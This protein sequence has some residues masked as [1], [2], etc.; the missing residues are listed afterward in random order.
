MQSVSLCTARGIRGPYSFLSSLVSASPQPGI[1]QLFADDGGRVLVCGDPGAKILELL[2]EQLDI[3][4]TIAEGLAN[5]LYRLVADSSADNASLPYARRRRISVT[6]VERHIFERLE[7][8]DPSSLNVALDGGGLKPVDFVTP[9]DEPGFYQ[10]VKVVPGHIASGLIEDRPAD[11]NLVVDALKR[12]GRVL[13]SGPSGSGKSAL[14]WLSSYALNGTCRWFEIT[15]IA[16]ATQVADIERFVR[17]RRPTKDSPIGLLFDDIGSSNSVLWNT[18][19]V[20]MRRMNAVLLL[21]SVRQ[22]DAELITEQAEFE[23]IRVALCE[24][25]AESIWRNLASKKLTSWPHWREPFEKSGG[26]MLEYVHILTQG[27]RLGKVIGDQVRIREREGRWDEL[28]IIRT[29]AVLCARGGDVQTSRLLELLDLEP[30]RASRSLRRLIDEH[31][32]RESE[33]GVLGGLH[34]LRSEALVRASH[35]D[36]VWFSANTLCESLPAATMATLPSVLQSTL[37][38][39]GAEM[40][41]KVLCALAETLGVTD[42][43]E[44][45][46]GILTGLGLATLE[47]CIGSLISILTRREIPR[48]QWPVAAMFADPSVGVPGL[49]GLDQLNSTVTEFRQATNKDLRRVCLELLPEGHSVPKRLDME[50]AN[51]LLS[52]IVPICGGESVPMPF[53]FLDLL[54]CRERDIGRIAK[55]M[56]TAYLI[57]SDLANDIAVYLG[58]T[59]AL[60]EL[61]RAQIP[62]VT[63]PEIE[64]SGAHGRTIRSNWFHLADQYQADPHGAVCGICETLIALVP[65]ADAAASDAID[66][67]RQIISVGDFTPWSKNA[68][69]QIMMTRVSQD[70]LSAYACK[71]AVVFGEVTEAW[72]Q[73]TSLPRSKMRRMTTEIS[74]IVTAANSMA[75]AAPEAVSA[76]MTTPAST[77]ALGDSVGALLTDVLGNLVGRLVR[78]DGVRAIRDFAVQLSVRAEDHR[79]SEIWRAVA[80]PPVPELSSLALRL[81]DVANVLNEIAYGG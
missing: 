2:S 44:M 57:S 51:K 20:V 56:S 49:P 39:A 45:W 10:G 32:V 47:R 3:A 54:E 26:L 73:V 16:N 55:L 35:D 11:V 37:R 13:V 60:F 34:V 9:V 78:L 67:S 18:I 81:R 50:Q 22:E 17:S 4:P 40:E 70:S 29:T 1:D 68:F 25:L 58:G 36:A 75:Y 71:M 79:E 12:R 15:S 74:E 64:P 65:D 8:I 5:D 23:Y 48:A 53:H 24:D 63:H 31:I 46:T 72:M 28:A 76:V 61:F 66:P 21:G 41:Q 19:A 52:S 27:A 69:R 43:F 7:D 62:W 33:P 14:L 30:N 38:D 42:D 77:Y 80:T 59:E 6:E